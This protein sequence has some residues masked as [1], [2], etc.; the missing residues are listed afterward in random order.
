MRLELYDGFLQVR[1]ARVNIFWRVACY[2]QGIMKKERAM[3]AEK[4]LECRSVGL[5]AEI[6]ARHAARRKTSEK[7]KG[8]ES[9]IG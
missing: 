4:R 7:R 6:D 8:H 9:Q 1:I 3:A 2:R 5:L